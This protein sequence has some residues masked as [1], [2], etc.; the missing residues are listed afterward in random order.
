MQLPQCEII[1]C[2]IH[3]FTTRANNISWFAG[4]ETPQALRDELHRAG[5]SRCCGSV[6]RALKEPSFAAIHDFNLESLELYRQMPDFYIPAPHVHPLFPE[7]S[8]RELTEWH[9]RGCLYWVGELVGYMMGYSSYLSD[10]FNQIY[11]LIQDLGVPVNIHPGDLSE[12]AVICKNFPKLN[13]VIAHPGSGKEDILSRH[14][15][16]RRYDNAYL[17]LSGTGIFRWAMLR[18][19]INTAG[20]HKFLFGTDFPICNPGMLLQGVL[21]EHLSDDELSAVLGG[22]FR[23]LTG[24]K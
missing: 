22:N 24:I 7:E 2:H 21:F 15:L 20:K 9:D 14:E 8:C 5:I 4:T 1:D 18:N 12:M 16:L 23:Q 10:N 11:A 13:V 3:P 17:D 19:G 6:I